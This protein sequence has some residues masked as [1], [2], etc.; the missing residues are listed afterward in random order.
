MP[1]REVR[2][3][4]QRLRTLQLIGAEYG[5]VYEVQPEGHFTLVP[6]GQLFD[7]L[8][9]TTESGAD[10]RDLVDTQTSQVLAGDD[11]RALREAGKSGTE[12]IAALVENSATFAKK[13]TFAQEKYLKKKAAK[14]EPLPRR[15]QL[16]PA[17]TPP[18]HAIP[19][20][21]TLFV[22]ASSSPRCSAWR[23]R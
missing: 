22:S 8:G 7:P 14:C 10:N 13:T 9:I 21:G 3:R 11:I 19:C 16:A 15:C 1:R 5:G 18:C 6:S 17:R 23:M 4:R 20:A 12:I 2:F